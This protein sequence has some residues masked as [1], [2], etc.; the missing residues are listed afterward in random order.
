MS[1]GDQ[2]QPSDRRLA[3]GCAAASRLPAPW[4][5][6]GLLR[7]LAAHGHHPAIIA[8]DEGGIETWDRGNLAD[9][10]LHLAWGLRQ[11]GV[12]RGAPVA[13]H[14]PN[15]PVWIVAALAILAAG[16]VLV[17]V[18]D[19]ADPAQLEAA[20]ASSGARLIFT[21]ARHLEASGDIL[22][23]H[24]ASAILVDETAP[25]GHAAASWLSL[26]R[27]QAVDLPVPADNEPA[28]LSWTSG[29]TGSPK[30][31]LLS[32][33]NIACN[34]E[35]LQE[36]A[37]IGPG[38]R[39]LL[40][41]P[42]HHAYP[43][44]VGLL[45]TL[46]LGTAIVFPGGT[47]GPLLMSALR[48][49][50]VT[51][52]IG[53]PRLYDALLAAIEA[54][55][56]TRNRMVHLAWRALLGLTIF[57]RQSIGFR[58]GRFLFAAVRR[59]VGPRLRLMASG[60]ARLEKETEERLEALGWT[61]LSG[62][63]LAETASLFTA[64][65]P[66]DRRFGS[67]GRP[68]ADGEIRIAHPDDQGTGEIELRGSSVT[69]G[70][71]DNPEANRATFT[72]D[73]WFRTGDLGFVDRDGFLFVTGRAKEILVLGGG[74]K[75]IPE[76]LERVYGSAAEI[77][78]I[79]VLE[80][81]GALVALVRPDR[82]ELRGRGATNLRDGIRVILTETAQNLPSYQR[83]SGFA[84]TDQPFPRTR[85]GKYRRFL[86]PALYAQAVAGGA[87][88]AAHALSPEDAALLRDPTAAAI[89][90]LLRQ[91]YPDQT[92]DL[93]VNLSLDLNLD[94]FGW[95]ELTIVLEDRLGVLL[96]ETD[97]AGIETIRDLLRLSIERRTQARARPREEPSIALDIERWLAPT[98]VFLTVLGVA[99]YGLNRLVMRGLFRLRVTG[100]ERLPATGPFLITPNHVSDLDGMAIA[101][102]LPWSRFRHVYWAGDILRLFAN[103]FARL[104]SRAMHLFP[105]DAK[106]PGAVLETA[107]RVLASGNVQVWFPEGWRSPDGR[108]Q[109]FLP[110][111]GQLLLRSGAPAV[112]A[113]IGGA[114]A[115]LPRGRR[116]PKL[117]RITVAFGRPEPVEALRAAGTGRTDEE[118]IADALHQR[119]S[120]LG[121]VSGTLAA[122]VVPD[123]AAGRT[124]SIQR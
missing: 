28:V 38:D 107:S 35:A 2:S 112:P 76:D 80:E 123:P 108:L 84:L 21:T 114:F 52:V 103:P 95:M 122:A 118:R 32:H 82:V 72:P 33:R 14:A 17:P 58:P 51:A 53:V 100:I 30:A 62:Y 68:L 75:V 71:L 124:G 87:R 45:S 98:G 49:G 69:K 3:C 27:G 120:A 102:V 15:S 121:G 90:S 13:L 29:T 64:N 1:G 110:G 115:A 40:P 46:T 81:K 26:A 42:L 47:T 16:G 6:G 25:S 59:G 31:F 7:D 79:V 83:L 57:V 60:G 106:H 119:V 67:A 50:Q 19:L 48:E 39:A 86:L 44:V 96:S 56:E 101:A 11:N 61:V 109:R 65:R 73:G 97:I 55:V 22:R 94:S 77:T 117:C 93:D 41:L 20:L 54:R 78:E 18:D 5:I 24:G 12:G 10:A 85:L 63:G 74:K 104:F 88:R 8:F 23:A 113:H 36:L 9:K 92:I 89:W 105:V 37:T 111:I 99:L 116:I 4:T 70:Y 34:V 66:N 91:R 43:F